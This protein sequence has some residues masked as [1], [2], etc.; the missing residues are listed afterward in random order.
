M[1]LAH[2]GT[3]AATPAPGGEVAVAVEGGWAGALAAANRLLAAGAAGGGTGSVVLGGQFVTALIVPWQEK[4]SGADRERYARHLYLKTFEAESAGLELVLGEGGYGQPAPA[5][6]THG[7]K[8]KA[9]RDSFAA[10]GTQLRSVEPLL[11]AVFNHFRTRIS[12]A[13]DSVLAVSELDH[14]HVAAFKAGAWAAVR[15]RRLGAGGGDLLR[16]LQREVSTLPAMPSQLYLVEH[17]PTATPPELPGMQVT[18]LRLVCN[19]APGL[20]LAGAG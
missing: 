12:A 4:L 8:L 16:V 11:T 9:L 3:K 20:A 7:E 17:T 10:R 15:T 5:F 14:L 2:P 6:F 13:L 19:A 1:A 18:R